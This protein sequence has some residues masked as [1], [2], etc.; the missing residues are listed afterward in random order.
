MVGLL[1]RHKLTRTKVLGSILSTIAVDMAVIAFILS[2]L[3]NGGIGNK[4]IRRMHIVL[5]NQS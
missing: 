5:L 4:D 1:G 2:V 3:N